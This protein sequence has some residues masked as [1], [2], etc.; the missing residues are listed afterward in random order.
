[1]TDWLL[2]LILVA[3]LGIGYKLSVIIDLL[4]IV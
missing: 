4:T 3:L 2:F 1:M